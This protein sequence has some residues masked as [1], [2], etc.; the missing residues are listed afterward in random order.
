MIESK[1]GLDW[2]YAPDGKSAAIDTDDVKD[3]TEVLT[4][5][6]RRN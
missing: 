4:A 2:M 5:C 1:L 3:L 6:R